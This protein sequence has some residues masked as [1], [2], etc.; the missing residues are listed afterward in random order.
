MQP[1]RLPNAGGMPAP[2]LVLGQPRSIDCAELS[3]ASW[4]WHHHRSSAVYVQKCI[5]RPG[6]V[7]LRSL[8]NYAS[9]HS[10][11]WLQSDAPRQA[12][13][14]N[15]AP[16]SQKLGRKVRKLDENTSQQARN[17]PKTVTACWYA[18]R[19]ELK[20]LSISSTECTIFLKHLTERIDTNGNYV[21]L[22]YAEAPISHH[23]ATATRAS[24][25]I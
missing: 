12:D 21:Q 4:W 25:K 19:G 3:E 9:V 7:P 22:G 10:H 18:P 2:Q 8:S 23:A 14:S 15:G 17:S 5:R 24:P 11:D 16:R 1:S 6:S 13:T 20:F